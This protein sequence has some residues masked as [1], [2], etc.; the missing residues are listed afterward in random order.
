MAP[1]RMLNWKRSAS[2]AKAPTRPAR[3]RTWPGATTEEATR[4]PYVVSDFRR[5]SPATESPAPVRL[6]PDTTT[7]AAYLGKGVS[8]GFA[9]AGS[10]DRAV[11]MIM[12]RYV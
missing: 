12:D 2:G 8:S 3:V 5:T 9:P 6:K 1:D 4:K 10:G 7:D 11:F